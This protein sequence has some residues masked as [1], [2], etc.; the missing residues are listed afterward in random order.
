MAAWKYA[1]SSMIL[2]VGTPA[3]G[4]FVRFVDVV[5]LAGMT[6][7]RRKSRLE[8]PMR[9][10]SMLGRPGGFRSGAWQWLWLLGLTG[11]RGERNLK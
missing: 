7:V 1:C 9:N 2:V 4:A 6:S 10:L 8:T 3:K 5:S 11:N